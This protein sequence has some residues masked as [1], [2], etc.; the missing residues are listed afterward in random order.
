MILEASQLSSLAEEDQTLALKV[1]CYDLFHEGHMAGLDFASTQADLLAVG[2]LTDDYVRRRK[3]PG[4]PV[5]SLE[6]R[7]GTVDSYD[8]VDYCFAIGG[9]IDLARKIRQLRPDRFIDYRTNGTKSSIAKLVLPVIGVGYVMDNG[10]KLN[11]TTKIIAG[12]Q[13]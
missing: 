2:V 8:E 7:M 12:L 4:R 10:A 6:E 1:G 9:I 11:S 5:Q 13:K 3:G